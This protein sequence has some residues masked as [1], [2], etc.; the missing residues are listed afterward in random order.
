MIRQIV[1]QPPLDLYF[2]EGS[3]AMLAQALSRCGVHRPLIVTGRT[4]ASTPGIIDPLCRSLEDRTAGIFSEASAH[5]PVSIV[6]AGCE[7]ART[8]GADGLISFGGSSTSDTMKAIAWGL[9][10][11]ARQPEDLA[12]F[13]ATIHGGVL[14]FPGM[15]HDPLPTLAIPTTLSAGEYSPFVAVKNETTGTKDYYRDDR[16]TPKA[17]ILD[18]ALTLATPQRLWL[19]S[20]IKAID[21]C[22]ESLLSPRAQ[23]FTD[24]LV[25]HALPSLFRNLRLS[26]EDP[27]DLEA[28]NHCQIAA[29]MSFCSGP[30][31]EMGLSHGIGTIL[32]GRFNIPHGETSCVTLPHVMTFNI[33]ETKTRQAWIASLI[34]VA[35]AGDE[36]AS[37]AAAA[38]AVADLVASLR[39]PSRLSDLGLARSSIPAIAAEILDGYLPSINPHPIRSVGQMVDWLEAAW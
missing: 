39:L 31:V 32:G 11:D 26:H 27:A 16:L 14:H 36:D 30:N 21:H 29:W 19:A 8:F 25:A 9:A 38:T 37:A 24:A 13:A 17:V 15:A 34:G 18:P 3:V 6:L 7:A 4:I 28:R 35:I 2:G 33:G 10:V 23:P 22:I 1:G 20:G 12:R 5:T